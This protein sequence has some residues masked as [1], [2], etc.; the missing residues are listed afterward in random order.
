MHNPDSIKN[1]SEYKD[2]YDWYNKTG[3]SRRETFDYLLN[4]LKAKG[5]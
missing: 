3:M 1:F 4:A 2:I 5:E